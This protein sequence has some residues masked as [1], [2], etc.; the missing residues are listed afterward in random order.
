MEALNWV[1]TDSTGGTCC[2]TTCGREIDTG[3]V[4]RLLAAP[5]VIILLHAQS[6][7]QYLQPALN[8]SLLQKVRILYGPCKIR[9]SLLFDS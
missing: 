5:G 7:Q 2:G 8:T 1:F 4:V 3:S 9:N 6:C